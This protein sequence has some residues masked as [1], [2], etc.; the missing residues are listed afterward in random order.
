MSEKQSYK[1]VVII[2]TCAKPHIEF[3]YL[4]MLKHAADST[5]FIFSINPIDI[6]Q[7]KATF[8][9]MDA[10]H[11]YAET[12]YGRKY[13]VV[14]LWEDN[15]TSF[16]EAC[17]KGYEYVRE[18]CKD[19][20]SITFLNDDIDVTMNWQNKMFD[21]LNYNLFWTNTLLVE[22]KKGVSIDLLPLKI[23]M[24]GPLSNNVG[25]EQSI[26]IDS[27]L[28]LDQA[29]HMVQSKSV[30][31]YGQ[32][33]NLFTSF[34]SGFCL[35]CKAEMLDEIYKQ[36]GF[37]F[38]PIYRIGGF[39]DNDLMVRTRINGWGALIDHSTYVSHDGS[40]TLNSEFSEMHRGMMNHATYLNKWKSFTQ[41]KQRIIGAY[42]VAFFTVNNLAQ[43]GS[44][45]RVNHKFVDG[46]A[47]LLTNNPA[48]SLLAYDKSLFQRLRFEDQEF[49]S[50]CKEITDPEKLAERFKEWI[51]LQ[52]HKD[53][54]VNVECWDFNNNMNER[55]ERNYNYQMATDM[56][57]D[58]IISID[59]DECF[60]DRLLPED[61]R[62]LANV[63]DPLDSIFTFGWLNHYESMNVI[64]T[65]PPFCRG[66]ES[67][68]NGSRMW[69]VWNKKHFPIVAGNEVGFHCGNCPE[70]GY[71]VLKGTDVR[72]RHLSMVREIDRSAKTSFY[73]NTDKDK[74]R[75]M[76]GG[77]NYNHIKRSQNVPITLYRR[78]NGIG[79]FNLCYDKEIPAYI[80]EKI[81]N[82][83]GFSK[84]VI[85]W[86]SEWKEEDRGW[87]EIEVS[88]FPRE[89]DW[90]TVYPT[91]PNWF[92][93]VIAS[94]Y[95][96]EFI[97]HPVEDGLA[98][99]RNAALKYYKEKYQGR[100]GWALYLDPD[101]FVEG[102]HNTNIF[103]CYRRMAEATDAL[104]FK[105]KFKN[106]STLANGQPHSSF[107]ESMRLIKLEP[108]LPIYFYGKA[109]ETLEKSLNEIKQ[110][111]ISVMIENCPI[112]L[113]NAGLN[114]PPEQIAAKLEKY[115]G[116]VIETL[117]E[118]PFSSAGWCSLGMTYEQDKDER[119]AEICYERACLTAGTAFLPFQSLGL[120]YARKAVGLFYA[121][122][123][124][125]QSV[126]SLN[127]QL[128]ETFKK[129]R[130]LVGEFPVIDDGGA[131]VSA[132]FD[133]PP[134]P[135]DKIVYDENNNQ[136][137]RREHL[138]GSNENQRVLEIP[139]ETK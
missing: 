39:E 5:L 134:F 31:Q 72:F 35:M 33:K 9:K 98:E 105:F 19:V 43:M 88:E 136:I 15:P 126:P 123:L 42:R 120:F 77:E 51:L 21:C 116:L 132:K 44:S 61:I 89:D 20:E 94:L 84:H 121:A 128:G 52:T 27:R 37:I 58:W 118:D 111:G 28:T 36:D 24:V 63:P 50:D 68:M 133:L 96:V 25:S 106:T 12:Y 73:N 115:Q 92:L 23:G 79:F 82:H 76:I 62:K 95:K 41:K 71:Y 6:D 30:N 14:K 91:G 46:M 109:H 64:R 1:H 83:V 80:A 103:A 122:T 114:K 17:N 54:E 34:L 137:V 18:N 26:P 47:I 74:D 119:N 13:N 99:C 130:E 131:K 67:G 4:R 107:S 22:E 87:T 60:E 69:R 112:H 108:Y 56:D 10:I 110:Q 127:K 85:V 3:K 49:L 11:A 8:Q 55:D 86:T 101:E 78:N 16:G 29:S 125:T 135:Y 129:L 90:R 38:D 139:Q 7:A 113:M 53:F 65:D 66:W 124:R 104:A 81:R 59:S 40:L 45:L 32:T 57:A 48:N 2:P 102:Y 97:Y 138:D 117:K 93:A 100:I 75:R 70:Y